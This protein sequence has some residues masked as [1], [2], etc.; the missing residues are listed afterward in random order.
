MLQAADVN[1]R[2]PAVNTNNAGYSANKT[3]PIIAWATMILGFWP[4]GVIIAYVDRSKTTDTY[5]TH[6]RYLIRTFWI[7]VLY[8]VVSFLLSF[9]LVGLLVMFA[10]ALWYLIR[11]VKGIVLLMRDEPISNAGTWLV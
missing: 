4:I 7:G 9:V 2:Y 8:A 3:L 6:Y 1:P 10:T 5:S 11:C